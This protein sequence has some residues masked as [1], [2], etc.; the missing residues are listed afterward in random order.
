MN[1]TKTLTIISCVLAI[2]GGADAA[3]RARN[4]L[5]TRCA[6]VEFYDAHTRWCNAAHRV[7]LVKAVA[8]DNLEV[9]MPSQTDRVTVTRDFQAADDGGHESDRFIALQTKEDVAGVPS[10]YGFAQTGWYVSA[11][12]LGTKYFARATAAERRLV[13]TVTRTTKTVTVIAEK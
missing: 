11:R 6:N 9:P 3:H 8:R 4:R 5:D 2:G 10:S 1:L 12:D 7:G 13:R